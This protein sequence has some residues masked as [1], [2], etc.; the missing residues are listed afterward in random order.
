MEI[1]K[2]NE[3]FTLEVTISE[4]E[5]QSLVGVFEE[6]QCYKNRYINDMGGLRQELYEK[7]KGSLK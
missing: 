7:L 3:H 2:K 1:K 5:V 6:L 4:A